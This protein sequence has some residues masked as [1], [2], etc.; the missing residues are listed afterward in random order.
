MQTKSKNNVGPSPARSYTHQ[1]QYASASYISYTQQRQY[2]PI[3]PCI[4]SLLRHFNN[5][6]EVT[7]IYELQNQTHLSS[8]KN[9]NKQHTNF[10]AVRSSIC[11]SST[12][13]RCASPYWFWPRR[14]RPLEVWTHGDGWVRLSIDFVS[15]SK[16]LFN[17]TLSINQV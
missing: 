15:I 6:T 11:L 16:I 12:N 1:R 14:S 4:P 13:S 7:P 2:M 17:S 8:D 3:K 9:A 5:L 10:R